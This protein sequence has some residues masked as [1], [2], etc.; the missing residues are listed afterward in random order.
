MADGTVTLDPVKTQGVVGTDTIN[1]NEITATDSVVPKGQKVQRVQLG[2]GEKGNYKDVTEDK[3]LPV[4]ILGQSYPGRTGD[5]LSE[6][7][8]QMKIMNFQLAKLTGDVITETDLTG[9]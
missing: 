8:V 4:E 9:V 1:T 3:P 7:L 5:I 6:I 2:V